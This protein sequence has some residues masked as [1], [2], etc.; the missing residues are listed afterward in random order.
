MAKIN[1]TNCTGDC[2]GCMDFQTTDASG[3]PECTR[4]PETISREEAAKLPPA[5]WFTSEEVETALRRCEGCAWCA[6]FAEGVCDGN[7]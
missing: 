5:G 1:I 4:Q 7:R 2:A 6:A 3:M